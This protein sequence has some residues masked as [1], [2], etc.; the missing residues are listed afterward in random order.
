MKPVKQ[1]TTSQAIKFAQ[2]EIWQDMTDQQIVEFQLFQSRLCMPFS[3]FHRAI[4]GAVY[5]HEFANSD[6]LKAEFIGEKEPPTLE[7]II[8]M[9]P[10]EK[11]ILIGDF[12][13]EQAT[14]GFSQN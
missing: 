13:P 12:E 4:S 10:E 2:S 9:I 7:E 5:T 6:A 14:E 1:L 3:E 8:N 11:R